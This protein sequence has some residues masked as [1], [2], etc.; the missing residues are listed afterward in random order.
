MKKYGKVLFW[1]LVLLGFNYLLYIVY[2][3][4]LQDSTKTAHS[5]ATGGGIPQTGLPQ[6]EIWADNVKIIVSVA[7]TPEQRRMG[8]MYRSGLG[9]QE[10]MLFV[11]DKEQPL[12]FWM[13][14]TYIPL[15]LIYIG[16]DNIIKHIHKGAK[17]LDL[18]GLPS[19]QP[20][21]YVV[22]VNSGFV[23]KFDVKVGE[24]VRGL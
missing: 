16:K 24:T 17:P 14:N 2:V 3:T 13:E 1:I 22:E 21:Q 8:L 5:L 19:I 4:P 20:A 7:T 18:T 10:G 11:F 15:D 23:D 9:V 12:S 6:K